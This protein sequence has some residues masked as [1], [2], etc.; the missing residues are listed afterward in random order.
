MP[1]HSMCGADEERNPGTLSR[2]VCCDQCV[3][4]RTAEH[5]PPSGRVFPCEV[6]RQQTQ[7]QCGDGP[8]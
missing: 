1:P 8:K 5:L 3:A 2:L 4:L 7:S 6:A